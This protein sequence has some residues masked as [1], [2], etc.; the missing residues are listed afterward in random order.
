MTTQTTYSF[1]MPKAY[2]GQLISAPAG[3]IVSKTNGEVSA[4]IAPGRAVAWDT[5]DASFS[6]DAAILPA[7]ADDVVLGIVLRTQTNGISPYGDLDD[8]GYVIGATMQVLQ[9]GKCWVIVED[10]VVAN[11]TRLWVRRVAGGDPEFLGGLVAADDSSDTIDCTAQGIFRTSA[12]AGELAVL[13][14]NF[15]S[16]QTDA[17]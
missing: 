17:S 11:E 6:D 8:T 5:S 12:S 2:A 14:V 4:S 16:K 7:A 13:E 15:T 10:A 9:Q 1:D 3:G